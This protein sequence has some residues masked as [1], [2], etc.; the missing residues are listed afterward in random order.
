MT[1]RMLYLVV[2]LF[3][4]GMACLARGAMAPMESLHA[5]CDEVKNPAALDREL[6]GSFG[7]RPEVKPGTGASRRRLATRLVRFRRL[8]QACHLIPPESPQSHA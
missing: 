3:V 5:R 1:L 7:H 4:G 8:T 2:L 6:C